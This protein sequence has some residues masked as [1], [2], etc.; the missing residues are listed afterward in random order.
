MTPR[1]ASPD[2]LP[3]LARL[4]KAGWHEA[5][6]GIVPPALAAARTFD[7][8]LARLGGFGSAL[9]VAGPPGAPLGFCVALG[10][11]IEQLFVAPGERGSGLAANLLADGEAR[12]AASGVTCGTLVCAL[13]NDRAHRFY[14]RHGWRGGRG[15]VTVAGGFEIEALL[16]RKRL[17]QREGTRMRL[18]LDTVPEREMFPGFHGRMVHSDT[19]TFAWWRVDAGAGVPEHAHP[20]EQV[21][22][23]LE[24]ELAL[25]VDGTELS[26]RAGDVVTIPGGVRHSARATAPCRVLDVFS[27]VRDDYR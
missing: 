17:D 9:R 12:L 18:T 26:L 2:E 27:P 10:D 22:N 7:S 11:E 20:H 23:M 24:G 5:H 14:L 1:A 3:A 13:G 16:L 4:W 21:V 25:T 19:M 15:R 8:F 6:D